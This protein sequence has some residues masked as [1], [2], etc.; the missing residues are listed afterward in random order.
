MCVGAL[1]PELRGSVARSLEVAMDIFIH[2]QNHLVFRQQLAER[3]SLVQR[4]QLLRLLAEQESNKRQLL[5]SKKV[6]GVSPTVAG[7]LMSK[8]APV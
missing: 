3:P 6:L 5:R 2:Q 8:S 7:I 4:L 1:S